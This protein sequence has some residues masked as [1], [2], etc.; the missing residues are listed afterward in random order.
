MS[1]LVDLLFVQTL[2]HWLTTSQEQPVGWLG[3]LRDPRVGAALAL[4]HENPETAWDVETLASKVGMS[5][6]S[7]ATRFVEL[8][9]EPPSKYLTR[10]RVHLAARLLRAPGATIAQTA[11][12]VG[13][14]SEAA[15]SRA[16][17]RYMRSAP[18]AFRD[19]YLDEM[20]PVGLEHGGLTADRRARRRSARTRV[21]S[22]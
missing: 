11:E 8:V 4:L 21:R 22:R 19:A 12:R 3:A 9:G 17:K 6:S 18:A 2:R 16:F 15:F 7:F 5:R 1:R 10:W 20:M 14:D 13:Y